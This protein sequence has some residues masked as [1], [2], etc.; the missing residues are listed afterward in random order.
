MAIVA[1][2]KLGSRE[3]TAASDLDLIFIYGTP[4]IEAVST[5]ER[6][7]PASQYYARLSQRLINAITAQTAE[8]QL[9]AVDMRLRPS[10][11]A[12]PI[13]VGFETFRRYQM[14][15]AWTWEQMALTRARVVAGSSELVGAITQAIRDVLT[16]PRDAG[17]L[18]ADVAEMRA[19]MAAEHPTE[20]IWDVKHRRGGLIDIEFIAQYLQLLFARD[21]P[22]LLSQN[23]MVALQRIAEGGFLD[24]QAARTLID[25]LVLWQAVQGRLRLTI[26]EPITARGEDDAPRALRHAVDGVLGLEFDALVARMQRTAETV[27]A[28]FERLIDHPAENLTRSTART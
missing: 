19:R 11:K 3:M 1:M 25:A 12:G 6:P 2:G 23:T 15:E 28:I 14:Y 18:V 21:N 22:S 16:K 24:R 26:D 9:Y 27:H 7:L 13:A 17:L 8:G 20:S 4:S 10:G 5:G